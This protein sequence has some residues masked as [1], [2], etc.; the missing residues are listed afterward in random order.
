M[1]KFGQVVMGPPGS[2]KSTYCAA[3]KH[4]LN[5][6]GRPTV[7]VNLDPQVTPFDLPYAPDV[8]ICQL[9]D[10]INI[11]ESF[12]LGPNASLL[13]AMDYILANMDWLLEK[14][15]SLG[16]VYIL[17]DIPG[18]VELFTHHTAL[19]EI[20]EKL[21]C[22]HDQRL[23]GVNLIDST[24]CADPF[25]YVAALLT[26]LSCQ[27]FIQLPHINVLSKLDLLKM[28]QKELAFNLEFYTSVASLDE[29]LTFF[30]TSSRYRLNKR[31]ERFT[32]NLCELIEDFNL[33]SFAT[34]DV[35]NRDSLTKLIKIIDKTTGY[36]SGNQ[37][38]DDDEDEYL[39]LDYGFGEEG[40]DESASQ[41]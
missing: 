7:V 39:E 30:K 1:V 19:R 20:I 33:V 28:V 12:D 8:D 17:Y 29:L 35:Q 36:I 38:G 40:Y 11:A 15:N 24:L 13:Y 31:F 25:K 16:D 5:K 3:A 22:K 18:Q 4:L 26:A 6:L 14:V 10:A 9:V 37:F 21:Q 41:D 32:A 2:G 27:I 23:T 34:L